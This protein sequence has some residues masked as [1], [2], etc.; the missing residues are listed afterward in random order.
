MDSYPAVSARMEE[1]IGME[2]VE[3]DAAWFDKLDGDGC[4]LIFTFWIPICAASVRG[5][6]N[7]LKI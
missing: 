4:A 7:E 5:R 2:T 6:R 1:I 3:D